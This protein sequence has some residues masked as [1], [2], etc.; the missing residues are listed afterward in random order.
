MIF[1]TSRRQVEVSNHATAQDHFQLSDFEMDSA[2]DS[3]DNEFNRLKVQAKSSRM[4]RESE[5]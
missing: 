4:L 1:R 2:S 5:F 3:D